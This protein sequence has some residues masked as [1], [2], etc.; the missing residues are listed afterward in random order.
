[1]KESFVSNTFFRGACSAN[2]DFFYDSWLNGNVNFDSGGNVVHVSFFKR[3][4]GRDRV[5]E[6]F[7]YAYGVLGGRIKGLL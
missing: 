4:W 2:G 7:D 1:L 6:P 5:I 3:I